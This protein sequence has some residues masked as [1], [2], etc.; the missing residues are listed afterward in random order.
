[1]AH[2]LCVLVDLPDIPEEDLTDNCTEDIKPITV[3]LPSTLWDRNAPL[4]HSVKLRLKTLACPFQMI[5]TAYWLRRTLSVNLLPTDTSFEYAFNNGSI[6]NRYMGVVFFRC[7]VFLFVCFGIRL[8]NW[9][10]KMP[11][12]DTSCSKRS[13][14]LTWVVWLDFF[15]WVPL[16]L[17]CSH[18]LSVVI[19]ETKDLCK[20]N[21]HDLILVIFP[22]LSGHCSGHWRW[23]VF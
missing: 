23:Y 9:Q 6:S 17:Q 13:C 3:S 20:H 2:L 1:M 4:V 19:K 15:L 5:Q 12:W 7:S 8:C 16:T 10:P 21:P 18:C 22:I 14:L 11:V